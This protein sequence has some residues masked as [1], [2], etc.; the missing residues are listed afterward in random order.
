MC[1]Y[2]TIIFNLEEILL[3]SDTQLQEGTIKML[4]NL[5][6]EG[7][8]LCICTNS[9]REY[10]NKTLEIFRIRD[11]F[12]IIKSK[13]EE[14]TK[15]QLIKQIL[16]ENGCCSA[17]IVGNTSIDFEAADDTSCLSI[18]VSYGNGGNDYK[19]ADFK[20]DNS[21]DIYNIIRKINGLYKDIAW[22][23]LD[24]KS[25]K[26]P[27]IVGINGVDTS[28]KT[29]FTKEL[30]RYLCKMGL[31]IQTIFM[32]DFHNPAD[33][34]SKDI[35]PIISYLNNAFNLKQIEK[36]I[37]NPIISQGALNKEITLLDLEEDKFSKHK[38]YVVDKDT[39][40]LFEGVLLYREPLNKFINF[41]IFIDISFDEVLNRAKKRDEGL[42]GDKV[43][44]RYNKKY[45]PIQKLY[46]E[47][48]NPK[49]K[50]DI[51]ID[52]E[53]YM[54]PKIVKCPS[55]NN[56]QKDRIVFEKVTKKHIDEIKKMLSDN[57]VREML[58]VVSLPEE[59]DFKGKDN[60]SYAIFS[61]DKEFIG[62]VELFNISWRN[63]RAELSISIK[64]SMRRMGFAYEAINK[65]LE[66]GFKELGLQRIWLRVIETNYKALNLYKKVGFLQEGIC[67]AESLRGGRFIS[68]IQMSILATEW[69][70]MKD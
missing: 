67:R 46:M 48:Y 38:R 3:K 22:Q 21:I 69:I 50:S 59:N 8:S 6:K 61:R 20:A 29:T 39:I 23:I 57:E 40:V 11:Y 41:R 36:E 31:K 52:N 47:N 14:L 16:D 19:K 43:I 15:C 7:Y 30:E 28:G 58:G 51:I 45:I 55:Y 63:R 56:Y 1:L 25:K 10:V 60:L 26:L 27:L 66:I 9:N 13:A 33:I 42:F 53:D 68:Q 24:N 54:N 17:I 35:D 32:D 62:I 12:S 44:E 18:G 64:P 65:I 2:K 5:I 34:R 37:F 49:N 4:D 70:Q